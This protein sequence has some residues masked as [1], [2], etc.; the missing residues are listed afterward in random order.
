MT[1]LYLD[2]GYI[3]ERRSKCYVAA[4]HEGAAPYK[5]MLLA[6]PE[7]LAA[8][9]LAEAALADIGDATRE[10]GDDMAWLENRARIALLLVRVAIKQGR[11][12]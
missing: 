3:R 2:A 9:E 4:L 11:R 6:A 12:P 10:P 1:T 5:A 8:L 7:I